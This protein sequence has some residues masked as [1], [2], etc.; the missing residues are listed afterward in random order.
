[1]TIIDILLGVAV[2]LFVIRGVLKGLIQELFSL[3]AV[4]VG[5]VTA[6]RYH[7]LLDSYVPEVV[8]DPAIRRLILFGATFLLAAGAVRLIGYLFHKLLAD[9]PLSVVNRALGGAVGGIV[10]MTLI[11]V[12]LLALTTYLPYGQSVFRNS[13]LY[14]Y[15]TSVV[16]ILAGALPEPA[17]ELFEK[18]F[19]ENLEESDEDKYVQWTLYGH[20]KETT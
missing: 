7:I 12:L 19:H 11:G 9:S 20:S 3:A 8:N 5:W 13:E 10:G 14:P 17:R 1:M 15:F 6:S 4:V 16:R 2:L 18:H